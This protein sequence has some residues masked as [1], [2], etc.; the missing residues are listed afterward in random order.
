MRYILIILIALSFTACKDCA[1]CQYTIENSSGVL[2]EG[3]Y[4]QEMDHDCEMSTSE[5]EAV[6]ADELQ[7][8]VEYYNAVSYFD[9]N[10]FE[11]DNSHFYTLECK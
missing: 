11:T 1:T 5:Y 8:D 6:K 4:S 3:E 2:I 10:S 9:G 7:V